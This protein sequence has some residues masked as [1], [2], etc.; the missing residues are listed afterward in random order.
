MAVE[1]TGTNPDFK[2]KMPALIDDADIQT[3][4]K[5]FLYGDD[6]PANSTAGTGTLVETDG[7]HGLVGHL[8]SMRTALTN[9]AVLRSFYTAKGDFLVATGSATPTAVALPGASDGY[10]LKTTPGASTGV[11]WYDPTT[12]LLPKS[13]GGSHPL[14]GN[15]NIS[16]VSPK[17]VINDTS[18]TGT[19]LVEFQDA[20]AKKWEVGKDA[21]NNFVVNN[22]AGTTV[23]MV[24]ESTDKVSVSQQPATAND[25][26]TKTYVDQSMPVG[27][28]VAFGS[29]TPPTGWLVCNGQS[30]SGYSALA[31]VVGA[32]VPDLRNRFIKTA[33]TEHAHGATGGTKTITLPEHSH[34]MSSNGSAGNNVTSYHNGHTHNTWTGYMDTNASHYHG[35]PF[36]WGD[37]DVQLYLGSGNHI[38]TNWLVFNPWAPA[39]ASLYTDTNHVH[40]VGMDAGGHHDHAVYALNSGTN[41]AWMEPVFYALTYIIKAV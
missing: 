40:G 25:V 12:N 15:L 16:F 17:M 22:S 26:A 5:V 32:N 28:I 18:S 1:P 14:T 9:A 34:T 35:L 31:A 41:G 11:S 36:Q 37:W 39:G 6:Y 2:T 23:L 30:T 3:A 29:A 7:S 8:N 21:S 24:T 38:R 19:T 27:S 20:S 4:L 33:G 13:A 10:V